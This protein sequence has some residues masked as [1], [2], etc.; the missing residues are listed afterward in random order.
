MNHLA[1][2]ADFL[3]LHPRSQ[4]VGMPFFIMGHPHLV[5]ISFVRYRPKPPLLG[6]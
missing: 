5:V 3:P 1:Q 4:V 2:G 6:P